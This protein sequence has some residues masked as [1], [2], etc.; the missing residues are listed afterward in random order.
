MTRDGVIVK[1]PEVLWRHQSQKKLKR[2][3][4]KHQH[5]ESANRKS[6]AKM[7]SSTHLPPLNQT[8][9]SKLSHK[10]NHSRS[11]LAGETNGFARDTYGQGLGRTGHMPVIFREDVQPIELIVQKTEREAH[12]F[13]EDGFGLRRYRLPKQEFVGFLQEVQAIASEDEA[14]ITA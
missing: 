6:S 14:K 3:G 7:G 10:S 9:T 5:E 4:N 11:R 2:S 1:N 13:E 12:E 8:N